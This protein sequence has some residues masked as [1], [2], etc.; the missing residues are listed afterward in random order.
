MSK[1]PKYP[2][3]AK[4]ADLKKSVMLKT[5]HTWYG[6]LILATVIAA[7]EW[8]L[9][10]VVKVDYTTLII[11]TVLVTAVG[12]M[13]FIEAV[14]G[15]IT[16]SHRKPKKERTKKNI[17]K[18]LFSRLSA[19]TIVLFA[20]L[21]IGA[22]AIGAP[23]VRHDQQFPT[24]QQASDT[25][26]TTPTVSNFSA[27]ETQKDTTQ[28]QTPATSPVLTP[29]TPSTT[30]AGCDW[31]SDIPYETV[32]RPDSSMPVGYTRTIGGYNGWRKVCTDAQG[33]VISDEQT[34]EPTNKTIY[35]GTFTSE[36]AKEKAQYAC[37]GIM[38]NS[39]YYGDCVAREMNKQGWYYQDGQWV[40]R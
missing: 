4:P 36:Q 22:A 13:S 32:S 8:L 9:L 39:T 34:S 15:G 31:L 35:Y 18:G 29:Q 7:V 24:P 25:P 11:M 30:Q 14:R 27:T 10:A 40:Y 17:V 28:N 2:T 5:V 12:L 6:W 21:F 26:Q 1:L 19:A 20:G 3:K 38:P 37:K 33:N 23:M 16:R